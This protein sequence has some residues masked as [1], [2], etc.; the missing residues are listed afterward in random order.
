M[1]EKEALRE[2]GG[3]AGGSGG[4]V[5]RGPEALGREVRRCETQ[6]TAAAGGLRT[7]SP[8]DFLKLCSQEIIIF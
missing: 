6:G 2:E 1:G 7:P 4:G 5:G 3:C 8:K